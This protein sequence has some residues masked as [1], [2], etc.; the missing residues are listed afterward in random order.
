[1]CMPEP[2]FISEIISEIF[3]T[4]L[5]ENSIKRSVLTQKGLSPHASIKLHSILIFVNPISVLPLELPH[6]AFLGSLLNNKCSPTRTKSMI[7]L[8]E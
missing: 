6:K 5:E 8:L 4:T 1:M 7:H 2:T 3:V